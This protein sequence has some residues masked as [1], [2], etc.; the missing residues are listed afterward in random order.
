MLR[1]KR[2]RIVD[3]DPEWPGAF[4]S[5]KQV[6]E[7]TVG[8]LALRIEHV[9]STSIPGL[10]AKPIID[11]DVVIPSYEELPEVVAQLVT[12]GY[13]HEGEL[14]VKGREAFKRSGIDVPLDGTGKTW[15]SHHLYVCPQDGEGLVRHLAFRDYMRAHPEEIAQ[16]E[17]VKRLLAEQY[18]YD[19]EA[20]TDGKT[21]YIEGILRRA[22]LPL[23]Q[24]Y[25]GE[26][27]E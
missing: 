24:I 4:N 11:L 13:I 26:A 6:I 15:P 21:A 9:G 5:I 19:G 8:D 20:Y 23:D 16:Y 18:P 12:L 17:E 22:G 10:S 1:S 14:G 25:T 27:N 7:R 2:I 3:Y